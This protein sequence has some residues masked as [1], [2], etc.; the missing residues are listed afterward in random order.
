MKVGFTE[1]DT[2]ELRRTAFF[3]SVAGSYVKPPQS[4]VLYPPSCIYFYK[5]TCVTHAIL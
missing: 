5:G 2:C 4:F 1:C 3:T